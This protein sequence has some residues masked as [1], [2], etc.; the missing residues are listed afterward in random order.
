GASGLESLAVDTWGVD[1]GL[2]AR[3]GTLLGLPLSYRDLRAH[4]AMDEFVRKVG[5]ETIYEATGIQFLP[6]NSLFQLFSM[7]RDRSPLLETAARLLFMP[8]LF[9][10]FLTGRQAT[11]YT[12]ASTSQ[13]FDPRAMRWREDLFEALGIPP[14][15]ALDP[16]APGTVLGPLLESVAAEAGLPS[17]RVVATASHD[18]AAAVAAM[19]AADANGA[20]IS[21]GTWSCLGIEIP[22]PI[23]SRASLAHNF[24][25]EGG[26]AG[27]IRF[28]KNVMGLWLVQ[29]CRKSWARRCAYDYPELTALAEAAPPFRAVIDPDAA[30]FMNPP[31][32]PE[33]INAFLRRTGQAPLETPG[34][35]IRSILESLALKYRYVIEEIGRVAGR[36]VERVHIIGGGSRNEL[37]NRL[38][39]DATGRPVIA[40][41]AEATSTGNI[42]IQL[43]AAGA[44]RSLAEMRAVVRE[45]FPV[46]TYLPRPS[47]DGKDAYRRFLELPGTAAAEAL[48]G[49]A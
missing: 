22:A 44:V 13:L 19:P 11:E 35:F 7:A 9:N 32:M 8:D 1:F 42:L 48:E 18:T 43:Q 31:D 14:G 12:I 46:R 34:E 36:A 4:G 21:S 5:R 29:G 10:F 47:P 28:L 45:S 23:I 49:R 38:T 30:D 41:P 25:N 2:L 16:V 27:T 39:A 15:I 33:A 3:D 24:T 26:A 20:F 6:F 40:G 17:T 37:L